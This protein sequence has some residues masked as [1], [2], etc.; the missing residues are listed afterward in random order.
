MGDIGPKLGFNTKDNG[1]LRFDHLVIPRKNML[2]K[3]HVV[4]KDGKYSTQGDEKVSYA[5]ML[6]TR[7]GVN[8]IIANHFSKV[9]LITTRYS[10]LRK[11]FKNSKGEEISVLDYQTQQ[12]KVLSRI[13]EVFALL[14][15]AKKITE[16]TNFVFQEAGKGRFDRLNE[17]HILA[18]A[19]KAY[20]TYEALNN[21]EVARRSAGGHG[22]HL[23]S[24]LVTTQH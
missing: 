19:S 24:G 8:N 1:Y 14:F 10:I 2:M 17:G 13:G 22:F 18:S 20:I 15:T 6:I 23:Y 4:S 7:S 9:A 12:A 5:T 11:Q 3:Y 21:S 16:F